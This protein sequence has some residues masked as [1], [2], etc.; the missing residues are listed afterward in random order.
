[1]ALPLLRQNGYILRFTLRHWY[2]YCLLRCCR[3]H[4]IADYAAMAAAIDAAIAADTLAA[5]YADTLI[6]F[7]TT[8]LM[9]TAAAIA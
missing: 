3:R 7:D 9:A 1:M 6:R 5:T 8:P 4:A 2:A